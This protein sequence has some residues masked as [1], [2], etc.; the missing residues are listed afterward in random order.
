MAQF[1]NF[2]LCLA[3]ALSL[4]GVAAG[5]YAGKNGKASL[6]RS[7]VNS[8]ILVC[9]SSLL[10]IFSLGY[11]FLHDDY[12]LQYVW[13]FSNHDMDSIYKISA[14]WGGMD[15][16]M[17]LWGAILSV[18]G[19]VVAIQSLKQ[20]W[21]Y[22]SWVLAITNSSVLFFLSVVVFLTNPFRYIKSS[23]I[24]VEGNGLNPLLQNPLMVVHPPTLYLG[25]TTFAIPY[26]FCLA[27]L[28][29]GN[30]GNEWIRLT[31]RWTLVA[32]GFLTAG[33]VMG[34]H[35]AY[36]ELGWGGFW[37]WD[38]VENASFLPWLTGSAFLH[39]VM[40]QERK[41][42]LKVWNI[43]LIILTYGLTVFGT[44]LTRSGIVQSVHAFAETD[45]G[46]VFLLYLGT[47]A[48]VTQGFIFYRRAALR[49]ERKIES[50]LSREAAFLVNNLLFLSICFATL[51]GVMFPVLSEALTGV[52]QTVSIPFFNAVNVPLFLGLIF[53]MGVGP[54]I[55]WRKASLS[56][57]RKT[58]AVPFLGAL[59]LAVLLVWAGVLQFYPVLSYALCA[60]VI[61]TIFSEMHRGVRSQR[62]GA[63]L[64]AESFATGLQRLFS[65]HRAR[66]GG[67]IVHLGVCVAT[68]A[69]TASMAH[70]V[71]K[72]FMLGK[73][74][75]ID[76]GRFKFTL[77]DISEQQTP[78]YSALV[79]SA[80]VSTI[81]GNQKL[82]DL[83][84]ELRSY[85]RNKETT[86]E[87]ALR[88]GAREDLY[89]VLVGLDDSGSKAALKLFINPLQVWLWFGAIIMVLG[90]IFIL[91]PSPRALSARVSAA[92]LKEGEV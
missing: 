20:S 42:M 52:K 55:A 86:T 88:V 16:S 70:K 27:A 23:F 50:F 66:Y 32:W 29:S 3:W 48:L 61:L 68:I 59:A 73:G 53:M 62:V 51:W 84:P 81:K 6:F 35:W 82:A 40:V 49:S 72:E 87:V 58:F 38:P 5:I 39:S 33:I 92:A 67:Y 47:I 80:T 8:T 41:N 15:G 14:I 34:G 54:L 2:A 79:A 56:A 75:S 57:L 65:R 91:I 37:A 45:I 21:R 46:W 18:S 36:V 85:T 44:F 74:E 60:F 26:A 77:N 71:E 13:Q 11:C 78:N 1:G 83:K 64:Q 9:L 17:L 89:L 69:I 4:F 63:E 31:R 90:T 76:I 25:F 30:L 10:A 22:M 7:V 43:W 12:S 19:A 28:V 24:P